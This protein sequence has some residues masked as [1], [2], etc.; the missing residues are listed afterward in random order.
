MAREGDPT[1]QK[2]EGVVEILVEP[3]P[4]YRGLPLPEYA[5]EF[6]SG[7]DLHAA[8]EEPMRI[9]PGRWASIPTGIKVAMPKDIEAQVRPRSGLAAEFGVTVLNAPGTI[10]AD[11]R[12]EI[13]VLLV[14]LGHRPFVV[15]RG[16]RIAQLVFQ[17][18]L[19]ARLRKTVNVAPTAR[20]EG[21]F[22]HTGR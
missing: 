7:V 18:V 20:G 8:V 14:N 13:K 9:D 3:L 2:G 11:Y 1:V 16:D 4:H 21:G 17:R 19:R 12:G 22:G 5:T 6:S 10:D 15:Q